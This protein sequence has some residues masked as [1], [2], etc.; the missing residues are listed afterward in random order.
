MSKL[1]ESYYNVIQIHD[2]VLWDRHYI[3]NILHVQYEW[4]NIS[5]NTAN[6]T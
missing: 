2:N 6:P 3:W 1:L 5:H 4:W